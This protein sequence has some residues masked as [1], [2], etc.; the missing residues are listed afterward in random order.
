MILSDMSFYTEGSNMDKAVLMRRNTVDY[1]YVEMLDI[2]MIAGR[3]FTDNRAMDSERKVILNRTACGQLGVHPDQIVGQH[4]YFDW[5]GQQYNFSVI[6]VMEDYHQN[7]LKEAIAPILFQMPTEGNTFD[8]L[9][10]STGGSRFNEVIADL[11]TIWKKNIIDTPFEFSFLDDNLKKQYEEDEKVSQV[12]TSFTFIALA[13]CCLGLYGLSTYMAERR[14]KEIGVRKVLGANVRQIV[15][16]MSL[17]FVKLVV[18]AFAVSVPL[19]WYLMSEWLGGFAYRIEI[20]TD[21]FVFAGVLALVV[22]LLTVSYES[23]RA[24]SANPVNSLRT[25]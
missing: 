21:I 19:A 2:K 20:G 22:A 10:L 6:G 3:S 24:A 11:E 16:M 4:I 17:E 14:I 5:Q 23:V 15:A 12:I 1:N 18:V 13:I 25:E 9:V 7:S 8:H